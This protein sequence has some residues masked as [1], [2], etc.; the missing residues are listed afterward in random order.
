[1]ARRRNVG[2]R[3][4]ACPL[5]GTLRQLPTSRP[6]LLGWQLL[7]LSSLRVRAQWRAGDALRVMRVYLVRSV[8]L[9]PVPRRACPW[10]PAC[11]HGFGI[12]TSATDIVLCC[13]QQLWKLAT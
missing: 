12:R 10:P 9:E 3:L 2:P 7:L 13:L 1:M 11:C 6:L 4:F 8:M 5:F